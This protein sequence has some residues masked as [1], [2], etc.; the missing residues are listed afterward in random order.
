[1]KKLIIV[2]LIGIS[3]I[4][5]VGCNK[6]VTKTL[7]EVRIDTIKGDDVI[8]PLRIPCGFNLDTS[9]I[10]K[11]FGTV[12]LKIDTTNISIKFN[13]IVTVS[14]TTEEKI[15]ASVART[16]IRQAEQTARV[17]IRQTERSFRDSM[18]NIR[19]MYGDSLYTERRALKDSLAAWKKVQVVQARQN[20]RVEVAKSKGG[21]FQRLKSGLFWFVVGLIC[22]YLLN[23]FT[24]NK[25]TTGIKTVYNKLTNN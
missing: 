17:Q 14:T 25:I 6:Y 22:G 2:L 1:M 3:L 19:K 23:L 16:A 7:T 8:V 5:N 4:G 12:L 18:D 9:I 11:G 24:G 21:W 10:F 20:A 13:P 15:P